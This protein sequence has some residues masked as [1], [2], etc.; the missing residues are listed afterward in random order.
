MTVAGCGTVFEAAGVDLRTA[1]S[2]Q[3]V[4]AY[5]PSA[6]WTQAAE[7]AILTTRSWKTLLNDSTLQ[8]IAIYLLSQ[9]LGDGL[10]FRSHC[11]DKAL[12]T[13]INDE[14]ANSHAGT[15][16]DAG[17]WLTAG[18]LKA[19]LLLAGFFGGNGW[20]FKTWAPDRQGID[21]GT[22]WRVV[23]GSRVETPPDKQDGSVVNGIRYRNKRPFSVF[24]R[25][26]DPASAL[27]MDIGRGT[28]DEIPII[29]ADGFRNV[30][31]YAPMRWR[32]DNDL[33]VPALASGLL[34]VHQLRELLRAHISGKRIQA[35][36]PVVLEVADPAKAAKAY[37]DAVDAGQ[38]DADAQILFAP[39]A[40][41]ARFT[42]ASYNGTDLEAVSNVYLRGLTASLGFSWQ[43][44]LCQ[45]TQSNMASSQ[46]ALDQTDRM[47]GI[48]QVGWLEQ[49]QS[50]IDHAAI[51]ESWARGVF[52]D[53]PW[54]RD[55]LTGDWQR[56][57]RSDANRLRSRQA[58]VLALQLGYSPSTVHD[59]LG[60]DFEREQ[61][62]KA[63][64]RDTS[65]RTGNPFPPE[66]TANL[67]VIPSGAGD[68]PT[69]TPPSGTDPAP[70][71]Q[72]QQQEPQ[73]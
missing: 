32:A 3:G 26:F 8:S 65:V 53:I 6:V 38:A 37:Q 39:K 29:D 45:L 47:A 33:G 70:E 16:L 62:R 43:A 64:D 36:N 54:T 14:V 22:C 46:A 72:P 2:W 27:R 61:E 68:E 4:Y 34:F 56:P 63:E 9:I 40:A 24:V 51:R 19:Q 41:S 71:G 59:E 35:S 69:P 20:G 7:G 50:H 60:S 73:P 44:V 1:D 57:R 49:A 21:R 25:R 23:D 30:V 5:M 42:N 13:L 12:R 58:A 66:V 48:Y 15:R 28:Y 52:G 10:W 31:H 17:A 55:L 18:E 67:Q 11:A